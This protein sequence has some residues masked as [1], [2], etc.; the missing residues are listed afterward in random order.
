MAMTQNPARVD[1]HA[2]TAI[3]VTAVAQVQSTLRRRIL[4]AFVGRGLLES[5]DHARPV[6]L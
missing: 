1:F 2:A 5:G 4:R 3:D 6:H